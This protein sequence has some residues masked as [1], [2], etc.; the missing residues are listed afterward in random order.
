MAGRDSHDDEDAITGINVTP[1]VDV[2]LVLVII[3]MVIAPF[4]SHTL[5]PLSLP[6]SVKALTMPL[7]LSQVTT[8]P[9]TPSH[10]KGR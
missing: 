10:L 3:F 5:K 9:A 2:C 8:S 6:Y 1:L 4:L 7:Q